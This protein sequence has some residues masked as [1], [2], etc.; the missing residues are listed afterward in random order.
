MEIAKCRMKRLGKAGE[1]RVE[2]AKSKML[3]ERGRES[4]ERK[5]DSQVF[6]QSRDALH[7]RRFV[8]IVRSRPEVGGGTRAH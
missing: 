8:F 1:C 5:V 6:P 4:P 2:M 7:G 3:T